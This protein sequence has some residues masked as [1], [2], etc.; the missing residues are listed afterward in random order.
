[1]TALAFPTLKIDHISYQINGTE[2]SPE[3]IPE[4]SSYLAQF[5]FQEVVLFTLFFSEDDLISEI[6]V[7]NQQEIPDP[8]LYTQLV[9]DHLSLAYGH[10]L[11]PDL[12]VKAI[13]TKESLSGAFTQ[14]NWTTD[15]TLSLPVV[16]FRFDIHEKGDGGYYLIIREISGYAI[17]EYWTQ[18]VTSPSRTK[19]FNTDKEL[20]C[21][22]YSFPFIDQDEAL[23]FST[24]Y[25]EYTPIGEKT[26]LSHITDTGYIFPVLDDPSLVEQ[27]SPWLTLAI[28]R[29]FDGEGENLRE[30][31]LEFKEHYLT[32]WAN[33]NKEIE[34]E[35]L[36]QQQAVE[37][38][39]IY[40]VPEEARKIVIQAYWRDLHKRRHLLSPAAANGSD[41]LT[42]FAPDEEK[43][44]W[45]PLEAGQSIQQSCSANLEGKILYYT[46]TIYDD[47]NRVLKKRYFH[48]P[49]EKQLFMED[50]YHI[51]EE[52][53]LVDISRESVVDQSQTRH[54][55]MQRRHYEGLESIIK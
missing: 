54:H 16:L 26:L 40:G 23:D 47:Q 6:V 25:R 13:A 27:A 15:T 8:L 17:E 34:C 36:M 28:Y 4:G 43:T 3:G 11:N 37:S 38:A 33:I 12:S 5:S 52:G 22:E 45:T 31:E 19:H 10:K 53:R 30:E 46:S 48:Q 1:M 55:Q 50:T 29:N 44:S 21:I 9:C 24:L 49:D 20:L 51:D 41:I 42:L 35:E 7:G 18:P 39:N 14:E 32:Q 2:V